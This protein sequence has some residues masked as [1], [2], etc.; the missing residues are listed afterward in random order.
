M[1]IAKIILLVLLSYNFLFSLY[2][3]GSDK[4]LTKFIVNAIGY[5]II[6]ILYYYAGVLQINL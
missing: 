1:N 2:R 6:L 3:L 5:I 4:D